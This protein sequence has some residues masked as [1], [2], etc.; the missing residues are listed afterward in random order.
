MKGK[1]RSKHQ[2]L[3]AEVEHV[4]VP[5]DLERLGRAFELVLRAAARAELDKPCSDSDG[6]DEPSQGHLKPEEERQQ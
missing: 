2:R 5:D 6:A 1:D 4:P 3:K